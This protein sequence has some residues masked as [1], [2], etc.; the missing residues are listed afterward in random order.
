MSRLDHSHYFEGQAEDTTE[1]FNEVALLVKQYNQHHLDRLLTCHMPELV[2]PAP[3]QIDEGGEEQQRTKRRGGFP[4][5]STASYLRL[6][7]KFMPV[8]SA[9]Q[10]VC[11]ELW[12]HTAVAD[13]LQIGENEK[14]IL[15]IYI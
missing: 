13:L 4:L 8:V 9:D 10:E 15:Y 6:L 2:D 14:H 3:H 1:V 7:I 11:R 5:P 12:E